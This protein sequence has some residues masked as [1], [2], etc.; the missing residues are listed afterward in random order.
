MMKLH[1][2]SEKDK[3]TL[4]KKVKKYAETQFGHQKTVDKWHTSML[5]TIEKFSKRKNWQIEEI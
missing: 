4:S 3:K 2:M 1:E 5:E